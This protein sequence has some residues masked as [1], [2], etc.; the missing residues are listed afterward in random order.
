[1]GR[2][3]PQMDANERQSEM[4]QIAGGCRWSASNIMRR[5]VENMAGVLDQWTP[6]RQAFALYIVTPRQGRHVVRRRLLRSLRHRMVAAP[7]FRFLDRHA[8]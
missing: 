4:G 7:G 6:T 3:E 2:A 8:Q 5:F 1:M